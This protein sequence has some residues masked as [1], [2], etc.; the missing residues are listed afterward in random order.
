[1]KTALRAWCDSHEIPLLGIASAQSWKEPPVNP[2]IPDAYHPDSI[3]PGT[4]SVIVI[5]LPIPLPS[6]ESSPSIQYREMYRTVNALLDQYTYRIAIWLNQAG[7]PSVPIPR[8]G[9]GGIG[10]LVKNPEAFFSH[11]H[12][13]YLAGIGTFGLNN[14]LLTPEYGP[15]VRFG[16]IFTTA[17]IEPDS[18]LTDDLCTRCMECVER[19]P[20]KAVSPDGYPEGLTNKTAC[21]KYSAGL[22][23]KAISPCGFCIKVCP[24]GSDRTFY[25]R[26]DIGIY[27]EDAA[28]SPLKRAWDHIRSHG[29]L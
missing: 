10:A 8:D 15:R 25:G 28:D 1:M 7:Y 4:R 16:S 6:L 3:F 5:G 17:G 11:R 14:M 22:D 12:A 21:A 24:V 26:D 20:V 13:A 23:K 27:R 19:C 18:I 9:Y 2:W 29:T